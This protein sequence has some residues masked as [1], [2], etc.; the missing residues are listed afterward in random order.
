MSQFKLLYEP[1]DDF[2][3]VSSKGTVRGG[4]LF[5]A[6]LLTVRHRHGCAERGEQ[7][8]GGFAHAGTPAKYE[9]AFAGQPE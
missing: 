7:F 8:R 9:Y 1:F 4:D 6:R 5:G 3:L 2:F